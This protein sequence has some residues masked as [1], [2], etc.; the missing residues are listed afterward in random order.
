MLFRLLW[1]FSVGVGTKNWKRSKNLPIL[2]SKGF[3]CYSK[4]QKESLFRTRKRILK[5]LVMSYLKQEG[6]FHAAETFTSEADVTDEFEV[7]DNID[8]DIILQVRQTIALQTLVM[9]Y[10]DDRLV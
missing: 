1:L 2:N 4:L 9:V 10:C 8:L 3:I 6:Y 5:Y 7:C